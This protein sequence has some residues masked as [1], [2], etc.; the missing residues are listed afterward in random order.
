MVRHVVP[1]RRQL[2]RVILLASPEPPPHLSVQGVDGGDDPVLHLEVALV[3]PPQIHQL[4]PDVAR[5]DL[6]LVLHGVVCH[7]GAQLLGVH[8][9]LL[10]RGVQELVETS[11]LE[12]R[13]VHAARWAR[14]QER[15]CVLLMAQGCAVELAEDAGGDVHWPLPPFHEVRELPGPQRHGHL[16]WSSRLGKVDRHGV[17]SGQLEALGAASFQRITVCVDQVGGGDNTEGVIYHVIDEVLL[18]FLQAFACRC[19]FVTFCS[20]ENNHARWRNM[21]AFAECSRRA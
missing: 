6:V 21:Q 7:Q 8:L 1:R 16:G 3:V 15:F 9:V 20:S 4:V 17:Q 2:G 18:N 13:V 10:L 14:R 5:Q 11:D 19:S 12:V